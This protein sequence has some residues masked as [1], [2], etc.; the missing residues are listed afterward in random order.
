MTIPHDL[1][2]DHRH[3]LVCAGAFGGADVALRIAEVGGRVDELDGLDQ[4]EEARVRV[5]LVVGHHLRLVHARERAEQ[6][7]LQ[8][9]RRADGQ[10]SV[11]LLDQG[12]QVSQDLDGQLSPEKTRGHPIV[13]QVRECRF[14][15]VVSLQESIEHV[16]PHHRHLGDIDFHTG[17]LGSF[18]L[19][20]E[21]VADQHQ[22]AGLS[23]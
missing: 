13:R 12:P 9:A 1:L 17:E 2:D 21:Q 15:Q 5:G 23:S 6:G 4:P 14:S 20:I 8:Q 16:G 18:E 22:P 19:R 10:R 3:L 11:D 7:V